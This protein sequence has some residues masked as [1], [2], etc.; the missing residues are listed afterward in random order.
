[1]IS[2]VRANKPTFRTVRFQPGLN[3]ILAERTKESTRKDSRNGLGKSTVLEIVQFCLGAR[4]T[5]G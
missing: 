3:L 1:M 5:K 4:A 2:A